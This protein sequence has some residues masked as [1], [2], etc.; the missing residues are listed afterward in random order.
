MKSLLKRVYALASNPKPAKRLGAALTFNRIYRLFREEESLVDQFTL[1]ILYWMLFSLKLA[2]DDHES[3]GKRAYSGQCLLATK[4][5]ELTTQLN[6]NTGTQEQVVHAIR[7]LQRILHKKHALF[8]KSQPRR[9]ATPTLENADLPSFV[10][11]TFTQISEKQIKYA[12][13]NLE[14]FTEFVPYTS[15]KSWHAAE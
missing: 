4:I 15:S 5:R 11:F 1:E 2:H 9:R 3:V 13:K 10:E 12:K 7:H 14:I 6:S 8:H